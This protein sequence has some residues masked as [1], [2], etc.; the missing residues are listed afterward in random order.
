VGGGTVFS[1]SGNNIAQLASGTSKLPGN[2]LT[3]GIFRQISGQLGLGALAHALESQGNA[4]VLSIPTLLTLDN[5]EAKIIVGRN[6]PF[7]TGQFTTSAATGSAGVNPFQTIE[8]KDVGIKLRVRP[9]ISE[10]GTVKLNIFQEV[11][12]VDDTTNAS[13]IITKQRSIETNVLAEDGDIIALGGLI[14]DQSSDGNEKVPVL[15]DIPFLGNLFKYQNSK[16]S[17]TNLMVFLRP[18]VIRNADQSSGVSVDRYDYMRT[19]I[20]PVKQGGTE[21]LFPNLEKGKLMVTPLTIPATPP[22][23]SAP[24][25]APANKE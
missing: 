13:G 2:G 24:T 3:L 16:R 15:G 12:S 25:P 17:K 6:V 23:K 5:E 10:G 1:T 4:N 20:A 22:D 8:R 14:D 9:Q 21:P 7:I 11:S 19:Q 18:T